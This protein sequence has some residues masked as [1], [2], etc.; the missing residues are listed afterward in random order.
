MLYTGHSC[1]V[2]PDIRIRDSWRS[3]V[4]VRYSSFF[5]LSAA[6]KFLR[7]VALPDVG[8]NNRSTGIYYELMG[9]KA[10]DR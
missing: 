2:P 1:K 5:E 3:E 6:R 9:S 4:T 7:K 8:I 10:K